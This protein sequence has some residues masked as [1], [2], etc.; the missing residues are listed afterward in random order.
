MTKSAEMTVLHFWTLC[1]LVSF[2]TIPGFHGYLPV[3][4]GMARP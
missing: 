1:P 4:H 2:G 3:L